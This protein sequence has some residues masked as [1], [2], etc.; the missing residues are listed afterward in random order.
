MSLT[1]TLFNWQQFSARKR[2]YLVEDQ[3]EEEYYYQLAWI[4]TDVAD[5]YFKVLQSEDALGST[6]S[7]I[8]A[9]SNQLDQIQS[10]YDRQLTQITD[11]YQGQ[12]SLASAEAEKLRI[13][14]ELGLD[15]EAL[16]S[17][18]GIEVGPLY[19]L[20]NDAAIPTLEF[21]QQYYLQ[22]AQQKNNQKDCKSTS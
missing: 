9:L 5:R 13:E 7:E 19:V 18:S 1:Q 2:A 10:L 22:Q 4:L 15:R 6:E 16:R 12:A 17:I 21:S 8:E 20:Q 3:L 14:A 11:L